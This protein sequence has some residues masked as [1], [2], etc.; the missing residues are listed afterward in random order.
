VISRAMARKFW[1]KAD[2]I[3]DRISIDKNIGPEFAT[4]PRLIIGV[5]GD[6]HDYGLNHDPDPMMYVPEAQVPDGMSAI[7][8]RVLPLTWAIRTKRDPY[9]LRAPIE[10]E[11]REASGGLTVSRVRSMVEIT[12]E[13]TA[14]DRFNT[15]LLAVFAGLALG[16]AI[17][18]IYGLMTYSIQ[19]RTHEIGVRIA[20]GATPERVRNMVVIEGMRLSITGAALGIAAAFGLT[21]LLTGMVY[22][23]KVTDPLAFAGVSVVLSFA[24][25]VAAYIPSR[26]AARVDPVEALRS[27]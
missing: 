13:S 1:P 10:A 8:A 15:L 14:R 23:V 25:V 26:R 19:Q 5:V 11:L 2:P 9:E 6:V 20:L 27:E 21:R 4:P 22:G 24:G 7:D 17:V 3:G 18:G 16:L 12:G